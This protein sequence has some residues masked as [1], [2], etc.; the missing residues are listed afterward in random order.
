MKWGA[1]KVWP[2]RLPRLLSLSDHRGGWRGRRGWTQEAGASMLLHVLL[3]ELKAQHRDECNVFSVWPFAP[4]FRPGLL[5]RPAC[6]SSG[7]PLTWSHMDSLS[8]H[9]HKA[10]RSLSGSEM[11]LPPICGLR[12]SQLPTP[13][14]TPLHAAAPSP[15]QS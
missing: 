5:H 11:F 15:T 6:R 14:N 4:P 9:T 2:T 13:T 10:F 7:T 3:G 8:P 12:W 1:N